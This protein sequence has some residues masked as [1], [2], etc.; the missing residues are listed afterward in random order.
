MVVPGRVDRFRMTEIGL[1]SEENFIA[2]SSLVDER[3]V[4]KGVAEV[5][6]GVTPVSNERVARGHRGTSTVPNTGSGSSA[7]RILQY[8]V[9]LACYY[10]SLCIMLACSYV[11]GM[12]TF[13]S[14]FVGNSNS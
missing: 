11:C 10:Y 9:F 12:P 8:F 14:T 5:V 2:R 13:I 3:E 1:D 4:I 6:Q 7:S